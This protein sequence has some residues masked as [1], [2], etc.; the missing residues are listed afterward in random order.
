MEDFDLSI[1]IG[2]SKTKSKFDLYNYWRPF[3]ALQ[4]L[5]FKLRGFRQNT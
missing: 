4:W 2:G 1:M 5:A 3:Q